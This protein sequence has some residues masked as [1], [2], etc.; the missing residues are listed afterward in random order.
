MLSKT[1]LVNGGNKTITSAH[2]KS[3][4]LLCFSKK[5]IVKNDKLYFL[6]RLSMTKMLNDASPDC[7][8]GGVPLSG[9]VS[10]VSWEDV[11]ASA[12]LLS[13]SSS[14]GKAVDKMFWKCER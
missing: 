14:Y 1:V 4:V 10:W 11:S 6:K 2:I 5:V 13:L 3:Y 8:Q 12:T 9:E 7:C